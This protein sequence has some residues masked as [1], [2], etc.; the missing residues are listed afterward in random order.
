MSMVSFLGLCSPIHL[1]NIV[2]W[3]SVRLRGECGVDP[4]LLLGLSRSGVLPHIEAVRLNVH[5]Q[6]RLFLLFNFFCATFNCLPKFH[7]WELSVLLIEHSYMLVWWGVFK[8]P[9][10]QLLYVMNKCVNIC[11]PL[12]WLF[13]EFYCNKV[14]YLDFWSPCVAILFATRTVSGWW[15]VVLNSFQGRRWVLL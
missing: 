11:S 4:L 15:L 2:G 14:F 12:L 9:C 3:H 8:W 6:H 7:L 1:W 13:G 10:C 5:L